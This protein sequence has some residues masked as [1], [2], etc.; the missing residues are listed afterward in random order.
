MVHDLS[1][2]ELSQQSGRFVRVLPQDP[3]RQA[4]E[5]VGRSNSRAGGFYLPR[6]LGAVGLLVGVVT[7]APGS[8]A[9]EWIKD[10]DGS[11]SEGMN[12]S[13]GIPPNGSTATA[14]LGGVITADHTILLNEPVTLA[15]LNIDNAHN[16]TIEPLSASDTLSLSNINVTN[17]HGNGA[18]Q[19][20]GAVEIVNSPSLN[21]SVND[22]NVAG[23]TMTSTIRGGGALIKRGAGTLTLTGVNTYT[24]ETIVQGG[25][26]DIVNDNSLP[27]G[28]P[29]G[30]AGGATLS[31]S[32]SRPTIGTLSGAGSVLFSGIGGLTSSTGTNSTFDG[33]ISGNGS[34]SKLGT[35][36]LRLTNMNT[37]GGATSIGG[38]T[39]QVRV[40]DALPSTTP[41]TLI[42]SLD[43]GGLDDANS[44]DQTVAQLTGSGEIVN[45]ANTQATFIVT[46]PNSD[47]S[48]RG[49]WFT[50]NIVGNIQFIKDGANPLILSGT[51]SNTGPTVIKAGTLV[52]GS[53]MGLSAASPL[54]L[55][56]TAKLDLNGFDPTVAGLDGPAGSKVTN[57][58]MVLSDFHVAVPNEVTSIFAGSIDGPIRLRKEGAG[59]LTLAGEN[60]YNRGTLIRAG[61]LVAANN[62]ALG[63]LDTNVANGATLGL[64]GGINL[65]QD[66]AINGAG[67]GGNGAIQNIAGDNTLTGTITLRSNSQITATNGTM[68]LP[69][70]INKNG[71]ILVLNGFVAG[72]PAI[73][74]PGSVIGL[75][76][77]VVTGPGTIELSGANTYTGPTTV[78]SGKLLV[79]NPAGSGTGT[80]R[81]TVNGPGTLAGGGTIT[82]PMLV[83][84]NGHL[85]PGS[86]APGLLSA[87]GGVTLA[88]AASFDAELGSANPN[89]SSYTQLRVT[90]GTSLDGSELDVTLD[91]PPVLGA[92]YDILRDLDN[93]AIIG[94][95]AGLPDDG[96]TFDVGS[97]FGAF[98]FDITYHGGDSIYDDG[99]MNDVVLTALAPVT[100]PA[101]LLGSGLSGL[102]VALFLLMGRVT[103]RC[104]QV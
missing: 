63:K 76:D 54:Q 98:E 2:S 78:N 104:R 64:Q 13:G 52:L 57:T 59:T 50:G 24:G 94:R 19:V 41:L 32:G 85:H 88:P 55:Q 11:W 14:L 49:T 10:A 102:A 34:F 71:D 26:L 1:R 47:P 79:D 91:A 38:G 6:S 77:L 37:Y 73:R 96:D 70:T 103:L 22:T 56:G 100:V 101:P 51:N 15:T 89:S 97:A 39:I 18:H 12:W 30:V 16:Y 35:G 25:T 82:G 67:V 95:F 86:D 36:I 61:T 74:I 7:A 99:S 60:T 83:N 27:R 44:F 65:T 62:K 28:T 40:A 81:V 20:N 21:V 87:L 42:G 43:L 33:V 45:R 17:M 48:S 9:Q 23:L 46:N 31:L 90:G 8:S 72:P 4:S 5:P 93:Q 75:G 69:G 66:V 53:N 29:V 80:G 3:R 92:E 68:T 58:A 84:S